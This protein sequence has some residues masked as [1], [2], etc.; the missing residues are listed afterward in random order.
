MVKA[1]TAIIM[2]LNSSE[3]PSM[4]KDELQKRVWSFQEQYIGQIAHYKFKPPVK[5]GGKPRFSQYEGL[6]H[7]DDMS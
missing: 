2:R 5:A 7:P 6:R 1:K 4:N 3:D